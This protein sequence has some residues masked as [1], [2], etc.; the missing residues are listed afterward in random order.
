MIFAAGLDLG[1]AQDFSAL[2]VIEAR[3]TE[4]KFPAGTVEGPP[5]SQLHVRHV[6]RFPLQTK[7][8]RIAALVTERFR[9]IPQPRYFAIDNTGVGNA[10]VE[11]LMH[12]NPIRITITSGNEATRGNTP[13][14]IGVPKRDLVAALQVPLQNGV[15]KIAH[16]LQ[17]ANLLISEMEN[18]RAKISIAGH[19]SYEALRENAHD[20]LVLAAAMATYCA[21]L[22]FKVRHAEALERAQWDEALE[23]ARGYQ[24]SAI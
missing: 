20:D 12:L 8:Q 7:Y 11:M 2:V 6:E 10:A 23:R 19:D 13:Q 14:E 17:H 21:D 9:N 16:G 24:I 15:L 3:G 1:Q 22:V 5:V 4:R 18:F